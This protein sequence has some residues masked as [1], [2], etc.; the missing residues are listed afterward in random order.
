MISGD[1]KHR[2]PRL[3]ALERR[4]NRHFYEKYLTEGLA[5]RPDQPSVAA[6][7]AEYISWQGAR[8]FWMALT[9]LGWVPAVIGVTLGDVPLGVI[10]YVWLVLSWGMLLIR[11]WQSR[12]C[13]PTWR[14]YSVDPARSDWS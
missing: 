4:L 9:L 10:G 1:P 14:K 12:R 7:R 13:N 2:R 11:G 8:R 3:S 6:Q 5:F